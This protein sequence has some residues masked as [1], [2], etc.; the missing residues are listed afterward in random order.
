MVYQNKNVPKCYHQS[1]ISVRTA[2][3]LWWFLAE[4]WSSWS[5]SCR[6]LTK[7]QSQLLSIKCTPPRTRSLSALS[8]SL[9]CLRKADG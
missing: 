3:D 9:A 2:K 5:L 1:E 7:G 6:P 8:L 4:R